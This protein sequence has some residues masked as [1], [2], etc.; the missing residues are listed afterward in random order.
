P[1]PNSQQLLDASAPVR[2]EALAALTM[3]LPFGES[4][5]DE[6]I[7]AEPPNALV[8][9]L[10]WAE[11]K[12]LLP[13][14]WLNGLL[15]MHSLSLVRS[16]FLLGTVRPTG[17]WYYFPLAI[18][19]K[20]PTAT[21]AAMAIAIASVLFFTT[22]SE[23]NVEN[24]THW[25][26]AILCLGLPASVYGFS[27]LSSA[28]NL[29][30]RHVFPI[31]PFIF[32]AVALG[33]SRLIMNMRRTGTILVVLLMIGLAS[34]SLAAYPNYI[35][36]F[37]TPSGGAAGGIR[38]LG[39]SNL[40]W[41]QDLKLLVAW[42]EAHMDKPMWLAYF[43][44]ADPLYYGIHEH[45]MSGTDEDAFNTAPAGPCYYVVSATNL[46]FGINLSD[47]TVAR[48]FNDLL[49]RH[50]PIAILGGTIYIYDLT[51]R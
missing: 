34:E 35:A 6:M 27:A 19:F 50:T 14:A 9:L 30:V 51:H 5:T 44:Q 29:G 45:N 16:T 46:Q 37:N 13:Q 32:I 38:L 23:N 39:D 25:R 41:G 42:R 15:S 33:L 12:H 28:L 31:Y 11:S 49:F 1:I 17:T 3:R 20:T 43:G 7:R 48:F 8:G 2:R 4:I 26:W 47:Q 22:D 10:L 40:D 21:L 18:L 36:F 24:Y